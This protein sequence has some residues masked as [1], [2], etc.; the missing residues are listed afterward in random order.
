M[1]QMRKALIVDAGCDLSEATRK[2][3]GM[4]MWPIEI[5]HPDG[6]FLDTRDEGALLTMYQRGTEHLLAASTQ[7]MDIGRARAKLMEYTTRQDE[8]LYLSIMTTRSPAMAQAKTAGDSLPLS[9]KTERK[10]RNMNQFRHMVADSAQLFAGYALMA[11]AAHEFLQQRP[12]EDCGRLIAEFGNSVSGYLIPG[13]LRTIRERAMKKGEKSVSLFGYALG[14]ALDIKPLIAARQGKTAAV[15]KIRGYDN[16][17]NSLVDAVIEQIKAGVVSFPAI[18]LVYGGP[19]NELE[20]MPA[21]RKLREAASAQ[22]IAIYTS[23]MSMTGVINVGPGG[24]SLAL[25]SKAPPLGDFD[26]LK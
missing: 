15:T 10:L 5:V 22:Q 7:P 21:V 11:L 2:A 18:T 3:L 19:L 24:F 9:L 1:F 20:A 4:E 12:L 26:L 8:L 17:I 13:E 14:T 6:N 25:A 16:A 23:M